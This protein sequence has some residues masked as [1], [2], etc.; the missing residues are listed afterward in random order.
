MRTLTG[1]VLAGVACVAQAAT[2][3]AR[4]FTLSLGGELVIDERGAVKRYQLDDGLAP[5]LS[6]LVQ[7]SV[8]AWRFE[9]VL[10]DGKPVVARTRMRLSLLAQDLGDGDYQ[11]KVG[12]VGFGEP[13]PR[14]DQA[15]PRYPKAALKAGVEARVI[16]TLRV[17]A[18]GNVV[19]ALPYQTSLSRKGHEARFRKLFEDVSLEAVRGW[20]YQPGEEIGGVPVAGVVLVPLEYTLAQGSTKKEMERHNK[21]WRSYLPGPVTPAPWADA[22][23]LPAAAGDVLAEAVA[24]QTRFRLRSDVVGKTL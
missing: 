2:P 19:D 23:T 8:E 4:E 16:L 20:K 13:K 9:P 21:R 24:L 15:P 11:L 10:V 18:E 1:F 12:S 7:R 6:D 14:P 22:P 3:A 17:D 5:V